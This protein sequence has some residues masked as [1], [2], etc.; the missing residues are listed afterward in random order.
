MLLDGRLL[1]LGLADRRTHDDA[2]GNDTEQEFWCSTQSLLVLLS[3]TRSRARS[4]D[5][6]AQLWYAARLFCEATMPTDPRS[7]D[8]YWHADDNIKAMCAKD[9]NT[10]RTCGCLQE[11]LGQQLPTL[12]GN[13][14]QWYAFLVLDHFLQ[15]E[16]ECDALRGWVRH[17]LSD[18]SVAVSRRPEVWA[19]GRWHKSSNAA[20]DGP[21][22]RW[23]TDFHA[24]QYCLN[25]ALTEGQAGSV[26]EASRSMDATTSESMA[27]GWRK[28]EMS[29]YRAS[30]RLSFQSA[31]AVSVMVDGARVGKPAR[32]LLWGAMP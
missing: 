26:G 28:Q 6:R 32:E 29:A 16:A 21:S 30:C 25:V 3:I 20:V 14:P 22:K 19:E 2:V 5:R 18:M 7:Q 13:S 31:Q 10:N 1:P 4:L 24:K 12:E 9:T 17:M 23:R 11:V 15:S 27:I 8:Q